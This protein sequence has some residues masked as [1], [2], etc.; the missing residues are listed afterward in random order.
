MFLVD[1]IGIEDHSTGTDKNGIIHCS[2]FGT[3]RQNI[4]KDIEKNFC[5]RPGK[6]PMSKLF[7]I[8][9]NYHIINA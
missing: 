3:V 8:N 1:K 4:G 2:L 7:S 9:E 6:H 5:R